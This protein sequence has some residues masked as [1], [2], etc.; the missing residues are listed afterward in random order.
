MNTFREPAGN[1]WNNWI[2][3]LKRFPSV[4]WT[5]GWQRAAD[6]VP[7]GSSWCTT[8]GKRVHTRFSMTGT[9][10]TAWNT[11]RGA[12]RWTSSGG[13][14]QRWR[15]FFGSLLI[16]VVAC[17]GDPPTSNVPVAAVE[18][19]A[20][21]TALTPGQSMQLAAVAVD[22]GGA[23]IP[24]AGK[25]AWESGSETVLTVSGSGQVH[26]L[27]AGSAA[28]S[29]TVRGVTGTILV[30]VLPPG[31]GA[32]VT[33]PGNS[34]VPYQVEVQTGQRVF[35]DFPVQPHNV[36]FQPQAGAPADIQTTSSEVVSRQ[37]N[38]AGQFSFD[39]T[40]HPGMSGV[41]VVK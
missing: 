13:S 2:C 40:L 15:T 32:V 20:P 23:A 24:N 33:M 16:S 34:F 10:G 9:A 27:T 22:A 17:G 29:A 37:F 3:F 19:T 4:R 6:P 28:V 38:T 8:K 36:I 31:A 1:K 7:E 39:C 26:A 25:V 21:A 14:E 5:T 35:F 12:V 11:A 41:V 18:I 30:T